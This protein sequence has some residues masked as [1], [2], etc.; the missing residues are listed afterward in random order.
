MI[1]LY[2]PAPRVNKLRKTKDGFK[3]QANGKR[4][5]AVQRPAWLNAN[6]RLG[7][8]QKANYTA[9]WR[10]AGHQAAEAAQMPKNDGPG[11]WFLTAFIHLPRDVVYDSAN[12]YPSIKAALD[13][14]I[15]YGFLPDDNNDYIVGPL[16]RKGQKSEDAFGGVRLDFYNLDITEDHNALMRSMLM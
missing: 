10:D 15:D 16:H 8:H 13:G 5:P 3:K 11:A 7:H 6:Q 2:I 1:S 12:Y 14:I 4:A 9:L